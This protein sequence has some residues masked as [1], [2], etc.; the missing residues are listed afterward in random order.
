MIMQARF[1]RRGFLAATAGSALIGAPYLARRGWAAVTGRTLR[2]ASGEADGAKG[3]LDP[4]FSQQ[5]CDASRVALV[6]ERLVV[7]DES[8]RPQPQLAESW[9]TNETGDVWTFKLRAGVR[10]HD[11]EP[12][13]AKHVVY[14]YRRLLDP[15]TG[16][17]AKASLSGIDP[18]GIEAV[19][20]A[21]VRFRLPAP[22]VQF[23]AY[24]ANR[25][26]YIVRE[27]QPADQIR[28]RGIGTG[29]FKVKHFVPGED[30]SLYIKNEAYWQPGLPKV[31]AVELRSIPDGAAQ[32]AAVAAGQI[33]LTWDLPRVGLKTLEANS[34]VK[35]ISVRSPY[36]MSMSMWVDTA[37]FNDVRVRQ[38]LKYVID[39]EKVVQLVLGGHGQIGDDNPVASWVQYG[40]TDLP[41]RRDVAKAKDLLAQ[42]GHAGG[43]E[44]ELHTSEAVIGFIEMAT[45]FQAMASE[46]GINVKLVKTPAGEYWDDIWLK[47]PFV[48]S[49]WSGRAAD[50]ALSVAYLSDAQ[51]N[52][53]HWKRRDYDALI[54]QA[55]RTVDDA[56][57]GALYQQAQR[58]L[59]DEGGIL[60]PMF[61][62]AIG[63]TRANVAGWSL[64]PQKFT[65]DFTKV[66]FTS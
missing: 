57:R 29:P 50:E 60:I 55:R 28:T 43:L 54:S 39:R 33:D 56:K 44:I 34:Q 37:P 7:L 42:A 52:E 51:W 66:V 45:L 3:T 62:D 2:I 59:R 30:S 27:G 36:V 47:K 64:H 16:S 25:F 46:A 5:D 17:P 48:C 22:L 12:F 53:T 40:L 10:F 26:T 38:A 63:A 24:I 23:P 13:T 8:F 15:A 58:L 31:D 65:K 14:T 41:R 18:K 11:G 9:T 35:I 49:A 20:D 21:T 32:V 4:A 19:D 61:P 1:S 6:F